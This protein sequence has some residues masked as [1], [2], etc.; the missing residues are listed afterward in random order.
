M[1]VSINGTSG[2]TFN[3]ASTQNTAATGFGFKNRLFN[4]QMTIDQRN[5]GASVTP[6]GSAY[7]LDRWQANIDVASKLSFQQSTTVPTGFINSLLIT[8]LSAYSLSSSEQFNIQ[9]RVEGFNVSD[10]GWGTANASTVT[11]SFWVRSSLTG[12]FGGSF[13]NSAQDR[14]YP[15]S[16]TIS[17]ANTWEQKSVTITGDTTGTWLTDN[18]VGLIA[19]FSL[20]AGSTR[21]STAGSWQAGDYRGATGQVNLVSTNG[22]T[23][24]ITGVQLEKGSTATSFDYRPYGTELDLCRR[25]F[26]S[27]FYNGSGRLAI[28]TAE[29]SAS[30][31][32]QFNFIYP[33]RATPSVTLPAIGTSTGQITFLTSNGNYPSTVGT[34]VASYISTSSFVFTGQSFTSTWT[35]GNSTQLYSSGGTYLTASAEL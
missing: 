31:V 30:A 15:F 32:A 16:Y 13:R 22:A 14:S 18:G 25:Y 4:G 5:A 28:G 29:G 10:L 21:A 34:I 33:F 3:D 1:T 17:A 26:Q 12:T 8:S 24:Y 11:L 35:T 27:Y 2:L 9:Q 7:T 19:T 20:G 23:F 6:T